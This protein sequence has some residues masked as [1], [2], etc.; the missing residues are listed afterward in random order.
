[1]TDTKEPDN[2]A[3]TPPASPASPPSP[4]RPGRGRSVTV[5]LVLLVLLCIVSVLRLVTGETFGWP[6]SNEVLSLRIDRLLIGLT[7]GAGLAVA[8]ALLQGLLRNPLASPYILGVS[9]GA[10]LGVMVGWMGWLAVIG[11]VDDHL[12]ALGGAAVTLVIVL[13]LAQKRGR[14]D[15]LGLLLVGVIVN[16]INGAAIMFI[17]YLSPHG[18]RGNMALWL[19]GY[20]NEDVASEVLYTFG[21]TGLTTLHLAAGATGLCII[22]AVAMG[23][24]LDVAS[25]ADDEAH[26]MGVNLAL[27]R[28]VMFALA[29]V[30]TAAAV[31]L[32]GPIGF[33][34]LICPHIVRLAAGP[35]H[36]TLLIGSALAGAGLIV[37]ADVAV[38]QLDV[39]QGMMPIGVL[40][41][42]IGGP[43]FVILLRP[44]LGR[45]VA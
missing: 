31:V 30:M 20:F 29:G 10:A 40:T 19:L 6:G 34:G 11:P 23:R 14:L 41:A 24:G 39:G 25:F 43:V 17:N 44:Q 37:G 12:A 2:P 22:A 9:S 7:V 3:D 36:R 35:H 32:A 38:K 21:G 42:L 16:A 33:V 8:G 27:L 28:L 18:L 1:M 26:A 5:L 45:G 4:A 13:L 15:P